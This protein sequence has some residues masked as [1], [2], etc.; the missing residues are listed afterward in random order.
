MPTKDWKAVDQAKALLIGHDPRLKNSGTIAE[1][2]MFAD[3]Y[4]KTISEKSTE[5]SKFALA[6]AAFNQVSYLTKQRIKPDQLYITNLCNDS[7]PHAPK[8]KTV[9]IPE[10]E[11][12]KGLKNI[13]SI[14]SEY[15]SIK[16]VFPM[17][18]QV[19]YW[20]HKLGFYNSDDL[21]LENSEPKIIGLLSNPKYYEPKK[22]RTFL[23]ICGNTYKANSGHQIVIPI[24]HTK[25]FPLKGNFLAY[26]EN[27]DRILK[28]FDR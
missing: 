15:P 8:G 12:I 23:M 10:N 16:Y 21:F 17:S 27:Y 11:A 9:L 28:Y 19:N 4:F 7:L 5:K 20:L 13:T 22:Q 3:Y 14:L 25:N 18:L 26:S 2:A 24:L 1:Y 6:E